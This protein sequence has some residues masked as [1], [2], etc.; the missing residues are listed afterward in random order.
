MR[1]TALLSCYLW[2]LCCGADVSLRVEVEGQATFVTDGS[3]TLAVDVLGEATTGVAGLVYTLEI[4]IPNAVT[5]RR[6]RGSFGWYEGDGS[7]DASHPQSEDFPGPFSYYRFD[8]AVSPVPSEKTGAFQAEQI[9]LVLPD[10]VPTERYELRLRGV[11]AYSLSGA[12]PTTTQ[13]AAVYVGVSAMARVTVTPGWSLF[14][15]PILPT[16]LAFLN[17]ATLWGWENGYFPVRVPRPGR[18][19]WF[20]CPDAIDIEISGIAFEDSWSYRAGWRLT[21]PGDTPGAASGRVYGWNGSSLEQV[22]ILQP[23]K[24]YWQFSAMPGE[25]VFPV[26]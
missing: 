22:S 3:R 21:G 11:T 26:E 14:S 9:E 12:L 19:Y 13:N 8:S 24:G 25:S 6:S 17:G 15:V 7:W 5:I 4:T 23:G 10:G 18:G 16:D 2:A 20:Y 1:G